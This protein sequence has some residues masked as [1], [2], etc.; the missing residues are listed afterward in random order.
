MKGDDRMEEKLSKLAKSVIKKK[1]LNVTPDG[2]VGK[3][4]SII[5]SLSPSPRPTSESSALPQPKQPDRRE[6]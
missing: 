1:K 4:R 2:L 5:D 6:D 3:F